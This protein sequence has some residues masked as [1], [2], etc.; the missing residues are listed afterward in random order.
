MRLALICGL[1]CSTFALAHAQ[2]EIEMD[3][4]TST[5]KPDPPVE[6]TQPTDT[7]ATDTPPA[8]QPV[9]KDPKVA[10]KWLQAGDL[11]VKNGD[12][13]AK[14]NKLDEAKVQYTNAVTAY[15]KAIEA[16]DDV[17]GP[18]LNWQLATAEDKAGD[19]PSAMTHLKL[20]AAAQGVKPDLVKKAQAKLDEFSMK[21]GVLTLSVVP[22]GTQ[23]SINGK[24]VGE[25]PMTEPL[26]LMP[27]TVT[28]SFSA[29]GYQPKDVE[30]KIEAGSESERKIA[31]E[32]VPIVTKP[33]D[34]DIAPEPEPEKPKAKDPMIPVYIGAGAT[35]VFLITATI[36]GI[37]AVGDHAT[38]VDPKATKAERADAQS[39]GRTMAHI[40]D[41][42]LVGMIGA[43]AFTSY[44][45]LYKV[46][47]EKQ[48]QNE[49]EANRSKVDVVP[50]VQPQ[51]GGVVAVGSF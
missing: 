12:K 40:T 39:G 46:R 25:A 1:V 45:Y 43:A 5:K 36:T 26:V 16:S 22:D 11:L 48:A 19:T 41:F 49:R 24:Q 47:P 9:V 42:C 23:I 4:D 10:K 31:L 50:W 7:T 35:G 34:N 8:D 21:V 44:W 14:A 51:A 38:Y 2:G 17:A 20:L 30:F 29:V 6:D 18:P 27:G 15:Q 37:V 28:V 13:L 33:V 32:A 3:E